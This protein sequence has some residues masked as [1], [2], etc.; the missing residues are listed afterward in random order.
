VLGGLDLLPAIGD[1]ELAVGEL[2]QHGAELRARVAV[3][4]EGRLVLANTLR[5]LHQLRVET[6]ELYVT[7][8]G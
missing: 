3:P 7:L 2:A 1:D 5:R 8:F 6:P 4:E